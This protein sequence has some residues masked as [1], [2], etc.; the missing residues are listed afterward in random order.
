MN[1]Y[2]ALADGTDGVNRN[3]GRKTCHSV[4]FTDHLSLWPPQISPGLT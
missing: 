4:T 3:A 1:E 2:V